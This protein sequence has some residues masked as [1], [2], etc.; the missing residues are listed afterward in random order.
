MHPADA[1]AGRV[2][3]RRC[4]WE[5]FM[6]SLRYG[7][8]CGVAALAAVPAVATPEPLVIVDTPALTHLSQDK[9]RE[10]YPGVDLRDLSLS[11][12]VYR[13]APATST[14]A[15]HKALSVFFRM[16]STM[17]TVD[18]AHGRRLE[19]D[20]IQVLFGPDGMP[21]NAH[22]ARAARTLAVPA[23]DGG[24]VAP[25]SETG[26]SRLHSFA[27][28]RTSLE[29]VLQYYANISGREIAIQAGD[30]AR[31]TASG[32]GLSRLQAMRV[33][34]RG[35]ARVGLELQDE[36]DGSLA[37]VWRLPDRPVTPPVVP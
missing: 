15:E 26:V 20:Q 2:G 23:G 9:I 31:I 6:R 1:E 25:L 14:D 35:L 4:A 36:P 28:N 7:L 13:Y 19:Y 29:D 3:I 21:V 27:F 24:V 18:D 17:R 22:R 16:D 34:E 11:E 5:V 12:I 32:R 10:R 30:T 33:I 37:V 8:L